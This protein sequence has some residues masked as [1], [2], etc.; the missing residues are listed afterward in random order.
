MGARGVVALAG[1]VPSAKWLAEQRDEID[2]IHVHWPDG[3]WRAGKRSLLTR[4]PAAVRLHRF[5]REV[6]AR[7]IKIIWTVHNLER[8]EGS[9]WL[10]RVCYRTL[11]RHCDALICHSQS[12]AVE[13]RELYSPP[14]E[15][16]VMSMGSFPN[17]YPPPRARREVLERI[18]LNP[19]LPMVC[20]L[21]NLR[22]YKG[23][24]VACEAAVR[25]KGVVQFVVGGRPY[26]NWVDLSGM[27]RL[28]EGEQVGVL[29]DRVLTDQEFSDLTAAS[30][31]VV[32]PY[33]NITGSAAL[34]TAW[35]LGRGVVASDLPYFRE[36]SSGE[37][38]A[39]ALFREGDPADLSDVITRFLRVPFSKRQ[40]AAER[41]AARYAWE[42]CIE[43]VVELFE[44]WK[45]EW[46]GGMRFT[47]E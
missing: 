14:G 44:R 40:A 42:R 11:A 3:L 29:I 17:L 39:A 19:E 16:V 41:L 6:R 34:L 43:P 9:N 26:A 21:G 23:L 5:W 35:T 18:G 33:H 32:L 46:P 12:A 45:C 24:T 13:I 25:L 30:E 22:P 37:P 36:V 20:C 8:H 10:D 47:G 38:D 27:R 28:L 1:I 31:A 15:I 2:A 4:T 7:G